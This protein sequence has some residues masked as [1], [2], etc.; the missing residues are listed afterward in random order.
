MSIKVAQDLN[1]RITLADANN[2]PLSASN[3][4][5][6]DFIKSMNDADAMSNMFDV[7][8]II[9]KSDNTKEVLTDNSDTKGRLSP[10][11]LSARISNID[12]PSKVLE[13][14]NIDF[15]STT[16]EKASSGWSA[17]FQSSFTVRADEDLYYNDVLNSL[18]GTSNYDVTQKWLSTYPV[19]YYIGEIPMAYSYRVYSGVDSAIDNLRLGRYR[20]NIEV[21]RVYNKKLYQTIKNYKAQDAFVFENV[22]FLGSGSDIEFNRDSA[23]TEDLKYDFIFRR[24]YKI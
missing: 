17:S 13:S 24:C 10:L 1:N 9:Q 20:V 4:Y 11:L 22:K 18:A 19:E 23:G 16:V 3:D 21:R 8:F 7:L 6:D 2:T 14:Q 12:I 5:S 15:L